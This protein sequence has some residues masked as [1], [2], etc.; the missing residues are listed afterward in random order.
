[1]PCYI[2]VVQNFISINNT[3]DVSDLIYWFSF[4]S[5]I[6]LLFVYRYF[7]TR[8]SVSIKRLSNIGSRF[9]EKKD[10]LYN[11]MYHLKL[12]L[13]IL[14]ILVTHSCVIDSRIDLHKCEIHDKKLRSYFTKIHYGKSCPNIRLDNAPYA[15][16][17]ICRG[18]VIT[19]PRKYFGRSKYCKVC[20]KIKKQTKK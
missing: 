5:S 6:A 20:N 1:M 2:E 7:R 10:L 19:L 3:I 15:K 11:I 18:C 4:E 9:Y 12:I 13:Y 14:L 17:V 16:G 8:H